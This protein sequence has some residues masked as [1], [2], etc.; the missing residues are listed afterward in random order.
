MF[1]LGFLDHIYGSH[2]YYN[3]SSTF[4]NSEEERKG[5]KEGDIL[6]RR[7]TGYNDE[8]ESE[9]GKTDLKGS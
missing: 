7:K 4:H 3:V 8:S 9:K 2:V 5:H 6:N 1:I